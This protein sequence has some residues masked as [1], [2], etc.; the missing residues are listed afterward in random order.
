MNI[1]NIDHSKSL[2]IYHQITDSII[3]GIQ[4]KTLKS[5]DKLPSINEISSNYAIA[6]ETVNKSFK[7]L[8]EKGVIKSIHGKGFYICSNKAEIKHNIFLMLGNFSAYMSTTVNGIKKAFNKNAEIDYYFH[9]FNPK[10]FELLINNNLGLYTEYVISSFSHP[11]VLKA[12]K[13]IPTD[14]LYVIDILPENYNKINYKGIYQNHG[15]D[16]INILSSL[17]AKIKGYT[18][19]QFIFRDT[20]TQPPQNLK[21]SFVQ[22]CEANRFKFE[23]SSEYP[24]K[25]KKGDS[26]IVIDD[27]DLVQLITDINS[28]GLIMGKD[29]GVISYNEIPLKKVVSSGISTISTDFEFMG[30]QLANMILDNK[31][32]LIQ[33]PTYFIDR[34]SF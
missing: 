17:K 6:R 21:N 10:Q 31:K 24:K 8:Q 23:I 1:I 19:L 14:K 27:A 4:N 25:I 22:F 16:I 34:G 3:D 29:I 33:N 2:P 9:H 13:S 20:F 32:E 28:K 26:Y 7:I 11:G 18:N 5:G 30:K 12:L 15:D